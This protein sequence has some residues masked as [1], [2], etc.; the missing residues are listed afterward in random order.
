MASSAIGCFENMKDSRL[1]FFCGALSFL[2][3]FT[4]SQDGWESALQMK[5]VTPSE[6]EVISKSLAPVKT[7]LK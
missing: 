6:R 2:N 5:K 1:Q 3:E 7:G 4:E